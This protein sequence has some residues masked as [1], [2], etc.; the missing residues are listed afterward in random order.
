LLLQ[1][2]QTTHSANHLLVLSLSIEIDILLNLISDKHFK[3]EVLGPFD[4]EL[5]HR[6]PSE[7]LRVHAAL[8]AAFEGGVG[9][10][11]TSRP[12][13]RRYRFDSNGIS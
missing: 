10:A 12:R 8:L 6:Q 9:H 13:R 7:R 2:V 5:E 11:S 1:P 4:E 3:L